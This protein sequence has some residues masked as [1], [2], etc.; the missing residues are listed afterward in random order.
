MIEAFEQATSQRPACFTHIE[1]FSPRAAPI[2][3]GGFSVVL[4]ESG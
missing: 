2:S 3:D 4:A 1:R